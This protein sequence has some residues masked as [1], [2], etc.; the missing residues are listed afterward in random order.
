MTLPTCATTI[1]AAT[2]DGA[3]L[4]NAPVQAHLSSP[5]AYQGVVVPAVVSGTTDSQGVCVLDLWPNVLGSET[6]KY[7]VMIGGTLPNEPAAT[8]YARIPNQPTCNLHEH[9]VSRGGMSPVILPAPAPAGFAVELVSN[10]VLRLSQVGSD[11]VTR[12][13]DI[14]LTQTTSATPQ[15]PTLASLDT[16][17]Q[18]ATFWKAVP[19]GNVTWVENG[20]TYSQ[21]VDIYKPAVTIANAPFIVRCHAASSEYDI[22][23]GG[24]LDTEIVQKASAAGIWVFALSCRHPALSSTP[25]EFYDEDYGRGVQFIRS[26]APAMGFDPAKFYLFSQ[27][28]G[29][30]MLIQNLLPDLANANA[31][32]YAGRQSSRGIKMAWSINPQSHNRSSVAGQKFLVDQTQ[33]NLL[34]AAYPDDARQRNAADLLLTADEAVIPLFVAQ[35]EAAYQAEKVNFSVMQANGGITHYPNMGLAYREAYVARGKRDR[36]VVTDQSSGFESVAADF[37]PVIQLIE[38]GISLPWAVAITRAARRGHSV[39]GIEPGRSGVAVNADGTG[40]VPA[41]GAGIGGIADKSQGILNA[42]TAGGAGQQSLNKKPKL[43]ALGSNYG[44]LFDATDQLVCLKA[45]SGAAGCF[46]AWTT[47]AMT[48]T[49][50]SQTTSQIEW[51]VGDTNTQTL[52]VVGA[53]PLEVA[54]RRIYSSLAGL[55]ASADLYAATT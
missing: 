12:Y 3:P 11:G 36:I 19:W 39:I 4:A 9:A 15:P 40:G 8:V 52:A 7:V 20:I 17:K 48:T 46:A 38:A 35:Y 6:S 43:A 26:L 24:G 29:S 45:N 37:V 2:P 53:A 41:V 10:T 16:W 18:S 27:S 14:T 55:I 32:T 13:E 21:V 47:T 28:R 1:T 42:G 34:L 54:D 23:P 49:V 31:P 50:A 33:I 44:A 5:E 25:T 51:T 22:E 30:G